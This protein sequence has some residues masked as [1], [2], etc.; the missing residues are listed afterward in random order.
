MSLLFGK[1]TRNI[2]AMLQNK[3]SKT[4]QKYRNR[5]KY[6]FIT[7]NLFS[8]PNR[9]K[10]CPSEIPHPEIQSTLRIN[11]SNGSDTGT[12][13]CM[14]R[15]ILGTKTYDIDLLIQ[16]KTNSSEEQSF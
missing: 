3:L 16:G 8:V 4:L 6:I 5:F 14:A 9:A 1:I 2:G 13:T 7:I 12:Y 11:Q 10:Y 15:N